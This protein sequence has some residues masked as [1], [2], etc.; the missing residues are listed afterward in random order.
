[1][2]IDEILRRIVKGHLRTILTCVLLPVAIVAL[3][4][5]RTPTTY[6]AQVRLQT[7]STAPASSTEADG[8][9]SRVLAIAT[10]PNIVQSALQQAGEPDGAQH[11]IDIAAHHVTAERLG[12][13]SVVVLSVLDQNADVATRTVGSLATGVSEFMNQGDRQQYDATMAGVE[14]RL[15]VALRQ[16]NQ[17]QHD[18][19]RTFDLVARQNVQTELSGAQQ[20]LNQVQDERSSLVVA[21]TDR[22][23][24][25]AI[26]A[27]K[28]TV[29]PVASDLVP[30]LALALLL[31]LLVGLAVAVVLETL[32]PRMAGI[33][34]LARSLDA[35]ILG[36]TGQST[37]SLAGSLT[38]AAR[39]QGVETVVLLGVDDRDDRATRGLLESL[40]HAWQAEEVREAVPQTGSAGGTPGPSLTSQVRFTDRMGVTHAEEPTAGVVVVSAGSARRSSLDAVEDMVRAM[41]WPVVGVVEVT[42]RRTWLASE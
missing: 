41:R 20:A 12:E 10:T 6:V 31:G 9:S 4:Y 1:M 39:R 24:V 42:P 3:L 30:R 26:D 21:A 34:V 33:R 27:T 38:L 18:L 17:L 16:R 23:N 19:S 25:V 40:P 35:P 13:S 22:D 32:R 2:T 28:P 37:D 29:Q 5:L 11:A 15:A 7:T 36:S 8:L 14:H